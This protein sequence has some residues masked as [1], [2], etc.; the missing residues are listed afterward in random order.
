M[1]MVMADGTDAPGPPVTVDDGSVLLGHRGDDA[2]TVEELARLR[3]TNTRATATPMARRLSRV[4]HAA[5]AP[6]EIRT[7][8]TGR[9]R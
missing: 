7:L 8:A 1:D 4:Y 3:T 9:A 5:A 6:V 2:I